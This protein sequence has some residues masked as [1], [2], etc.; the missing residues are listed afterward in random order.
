MLNYLRLWQKLRQALMQGLPEWAEAAL[1]DQCR[2]A[3]P[4]PNMFFTRRMYEDAGDPRCDFLYTYEDYAFFQDIVLSGHE[5]L[6]TSELAGSH[7]HR[8][9]LRALIGEYINSG[10]GCADFVWS[11]PR[12]PLSR[13]SWFRL[14][15][16]WPV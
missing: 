7:H 15:Q 10:Q 16:W 9:S 3:Q 11:Y 8:D 12:S 2:R 13:N 6:C 5:V 14:P 4:L 1:L